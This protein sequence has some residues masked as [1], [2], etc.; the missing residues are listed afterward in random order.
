MKN[1]LLI[2]SLLLITIS[3]SKDDTPPIDQL[4]EGRGIFGCLVNGEA[5]VETGTFFNTFYQQTENGFFFN[6]RAEF[7]NNIDSIG[8]GSTESEIQEGETYTLE[9]EIPGNTWGTALF[10]ES[11]NSF[12]F[13]D[14]TSSNPGIMTITKLDFENGIVSGTFS[15]TLIHPFNGETIDITEG[16]FDTLFT[17]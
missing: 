17:Q 9:E 8:L 1:L 10:V 16:R 2:I 7:D 15:F 3:C 11:V 5:F 12:E 13:A 4:Q 6:I 14:T